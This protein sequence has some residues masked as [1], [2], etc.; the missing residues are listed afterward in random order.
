MP[1]F[2]PFF[3]ERIILVKVPFLREGN[4]GLDGGHSFKLDTQAHSF[5]IS[6]L[7]PFVVQMLTHLIYI[8]GDL[9]FELLRMKTPSSM[10]Q[11]GRH[12]NTVRFEV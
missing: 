8:S 11:H 2:S 1:L 12:E 9:H 7:N 10:P 3:A 5:S 4:L 6:R